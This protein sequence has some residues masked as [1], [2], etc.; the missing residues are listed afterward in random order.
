MLSGVFADAVFSGLG[1]GVFLGSVESSV[2]HRTG[3][4]HRVS[5]M[6]SEVDAIALYF[7][8]AAVLGC[9]L[10][11][12]SILLHAAGHRAGRARV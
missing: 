6:L 4:G 11:L 9:Y 10:I 8:S 1:L 3:H 7:P 5:H 2:L 12:I